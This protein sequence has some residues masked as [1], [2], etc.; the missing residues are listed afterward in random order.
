MLF[1]AESREKRR[2]LIAAGVRGEKTRRKKSKKFQS[3][4]AKGS[5]RKKRLGRTSGTERGKKST[6][7]FWVRSHQKK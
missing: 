1:S 2:C 4:S 7:I 5:K 6:S 3:E